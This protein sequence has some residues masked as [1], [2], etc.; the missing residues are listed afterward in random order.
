MPNQN[1]ASNIN[2][3]ISHTRYAYYAGHTQWVTKPKEIM[4]IR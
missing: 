1:T 2:K 3:N 4:G